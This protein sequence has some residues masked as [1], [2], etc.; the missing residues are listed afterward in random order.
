MNFSDPYGLFS[1]EAGLI[2]AIGV[3]QIAA[4]ALVF[5]A[6]SG[7]LNQ[8]L[9]ATGYWQMVKLGALGVLAGGGTILAGF[10]VGSPWVVGFGAS[11]ALAGGGLVAAGLS[12]ISEVLKE[13]QNEYCPK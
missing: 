7:D 11:K 6:L 1:V 12:D 8:A 13:Q 2:V 10:G 4:E 5:Y 3:G 9:L